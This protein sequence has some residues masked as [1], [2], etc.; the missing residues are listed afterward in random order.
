MKI[1]CEVINDLLPLYHDRVCSK[2]SVI[3]VEDH[4]S[5]CEKC[6]K[7]LQLM[8]SEL[9]ITKDEKDEKQTI[10]KIADK[11]ENEKMKS[12][13]KAL[14]RILNIFGS[15]FILAGIGCLVS[16]NIIGSKVLPDGTLSEPFF[17]IPM[18]F[19]IGFL[20]VFT[21]GVSLLVFV[22]SKKINK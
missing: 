7:E 3:L 5:S 17:L 14:T 10:K 15:L 12:Y 11:W 8:D 6:Q 9:I 1:S 2:E 16:F 20:G 18:G 19:L 13:N 21:F 4:L 22:Y